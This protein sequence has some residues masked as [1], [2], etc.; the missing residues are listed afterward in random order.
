MSKTAIPRG[1]CRIN[2]WLA[3]G[4]LTTL[5]AAAAQPAPGVCRAPA[6]P[7]P[8]AAASPTSSAGEPDL[9]LGLSNPVHLIT[10]AKHLREIDLPAPLDGNYPS[11]IRFYRTVPANDGPAPARWTHEYDIRLTTQGA[12]WRLLLADGQTLWFDAQGTAARPSHGRIRILSEPAGLPAAHDAAALAWVQDSGHRMDFDSRGLLLAI[13]PPK[14]PTVRIQRHATGP[15][16][17]SI[18][19]IYGRRGTLTLNYGLVGTTTVLTSLQTPA[20]TF[21]YT[22]EPTT[23]GDA[24]HSPPP[25]IVRVTR[26]DGMSRHYHYEA[27]RQAGH[28]DAITGVTLADAAGRAWRARAWWYDSNGRV[29]RATQGGDTDPGPMLEFEYAL[30]G[31]TPDTRITRVRSPAAQTDITHGTRSGHIEAALTRAQASPIGQINL[32]SPTGDSATPRLPVERDH[33][34]R[35]T[36]IESLQIQRYPDGRINRLLEPDGGWPGL[37]LAF[38]S[39]GRRTAWSSTLTGRTTARFDARDGLSG[40]RHANGDTLDITRDAAGHPSRLSYA[41][42]GQQSV[43]ISLQWHGAHLTRLSHPSEEESRQY[44]HGRLARRIVRRPHPVGAMT[45]QEA[46]SYDSSGRLVRHDLPEGGALLYAWGT[47]SRL[48]ALTWQARDGTHHP[49]IHQLPGQAGYRYGNGLHLQSWGSPGGKAHTLIL[50]DGPR[51]I[52][53]ERRSSDEHGR[54]VALLQSLA[55]EVPS[56]PQDVSHHYAYDADDRMVGVNEITAQ[57]PPSAQQAPRVA[58]DWLAWDRT[59]ALRARLN[60]TIAEIR[61]DDSGLPRTVGPF[62]LHYQAQRLLVEVQPAQGEAIHY[63]RNAQGH[64]I[65]RREGTRETERY[66]LD[67]RLVAIWQRPVP[68]AAGTAAHQ[69]SAGSPTQTFGITQRYLYADEVPVALLQSGPDGHTRLYYIHAD[70]L[71][72]PVLVTDHTRAIRW[73]ATYDALGRARTQGDLN[74]PLRAPGQD[75]DPTTGWHDNVFR[76]YLPTHGQYLEPDPLGPVP[77]QQALGYAAQQ[78]MRH[79][80][81]LGLILLAFDGTRQGRA[82]QSNVWKLAQ[83]YQ[84]GPSLYHAGPGN[85]AR[86]DWDAITAASSGQI[87]RNQW[88]SLLVALQ[89]AQSATHPIPIDILGFSRGAALA[90]D[91][92]NR[93]AHQTRNGWFS[94]DDPL[95]GSIGLCVDLRFLGLFDTVA[96]FGLLGAANAGYDLTITGAWQWVAHAV[97]LHELRALFPLVSAT[98]GSPGNAVEAPFIGAHSDIGGGMALDPHQQPIPSGDLS[99]VALNWMRWQALAAL[100]PMGALPAADQRVTQPLLHDERLPMDRILENSD[101]A[102][103]DASTRSLGLQ[104]HDPY[105]GADQRRAFEQFIQRVELWQAA[106][107]NVVGTVDMQGYGAWLR[108]ELGLQGM[109]GS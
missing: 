49:V 30:P 58:A 56:R 66:Y 96:Q 14:G 105:L 76:T 77:G 19:H 103:Q 61:R 42:V 90:R 99:D 97:A 43:A 70:A 89:G 107:G 41:S 62:R 47:G 44:D 84:D 9:D 59:G 23:P 81:P 52:W 29:I 109:A 95:R 31:P 7:L 85:G 50:S 35:L 24:R 21:H 20:G 12:G 64:T 73:S 69:P 65:R 6:S 33:S 5:G 36:A 38:D 79:I 32:D 54:I 104:R 67:N 75:E 16:T 46:F 13:R 15:L 91:F 57:V 83:I 101:R 93:I 86:L 98:R 22:Y 4:L 10:G 34:G 25:R 11:F 68:A 60:Q 72:A 94:Y 40:L 63:V 48:A 26:P 45:Y 87:L 1:F 17:G 100:V 82:N 39:R 55:T 3:A 27:E 18:H 51:L 92:A 2:S 53:G 106:P 74:L 28:P 37:V 80:D 8:C 108:S 78:P 88:Q 71:G 102:L